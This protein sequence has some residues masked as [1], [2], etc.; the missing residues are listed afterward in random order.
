MRENEAKFRSL[1]TEAGLEGKGKKNPYSSNNGYMIVFL[2]Q[3]NGLGLRLPE[4][5]IKECIEKSGAVPMMQYG[6]NMKDF[7]H[8]LPENWP[9]NKTCIRLVQEAFQ[10]SQTLE[11]K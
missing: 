6:K 4:E 2:S 5:R 3:E 8:F 10:H 9:D 11:K 7:V 1:L